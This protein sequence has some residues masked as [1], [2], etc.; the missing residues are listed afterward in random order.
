MWTALIIA[1]LV[2]A[3]SPQAAMPIVRPPSA[4]EVPGGIEESGANTRASDSPQEV[5]CQT[6]PVTGS[7]FTQR[8]CRTRA[9]ART[10]RAEA[11]QFMEQ[12]RRGIPP[13]PSPIPR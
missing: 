13:A 5:I 12:S 11:E 8:R 6:R 2:A 7:R 9:E 3:P 4:G 1:T 10:E